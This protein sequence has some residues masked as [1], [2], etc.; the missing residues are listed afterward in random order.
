MRRVVVVFTISLGSFLI[1]CASTRISSFVNP[2]YGGRQYSNILIV[3][4]LRDLGERASAERRIQREFANYDVE[5]VPA[6]EIF[7]PDR[8]YPEQ[9]T[10]EILE[11][12]NIDAILVVDPYD[13]GTSKTYIPGETRS[14]TEGRATRDFFGGYRIKTETKTRT[15]KGYYV[16]KPWARFE[17]TLRD[18]PTFDGVWV[19]SARSSGNAFASWNTLMKSVATKIVEELNEHD[20]L[21]P[22]KANWKR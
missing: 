16:S 8:T 5:S 1:S 2:E 18:W 17:L 12:Y 22:S 4:L 7:Y 13:V 19:A 14:T 21:I 3:V 9:V 6:H 11:S 10:S 15:S 20:L